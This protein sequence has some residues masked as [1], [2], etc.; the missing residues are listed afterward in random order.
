MSCKGQGEAFF[1]VHF[2]VCSY[3]AGAWVDTCQ[4]GSWAWATARKSLRCF[5]DGNALWTSTR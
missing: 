5:S 2:C 3:V 1:S 4:E